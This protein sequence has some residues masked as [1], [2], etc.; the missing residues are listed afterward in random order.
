MAQL[1]GAEFAR[2]RGAGARGNNEAR[3]TDERSAVE[4]LPLLL[5]AK[6]LPD[7]Q[8]GAFLRESGIREGDLERWEQEALC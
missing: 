6:A 8:L 4:K 3:S 1:F 5:K 2:G 7:E